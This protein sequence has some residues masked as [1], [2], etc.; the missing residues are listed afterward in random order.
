M[1]TDPL[2]RELSTRGTTPQQSGDSGISSAKF[3]ATYFDEL[4]LYSGQYALFYVIMNLSENRWNY[5]TNFGHTV[6]LAVLLAQTLFLA[7]MGKK[8]FT[9]LL[10]SLIAPL[11]YTLVELEEGIQFVLNGAHVFFWIY[12]FLTGLL[13]AFALRAVKRATS[14]VLE[15]SITTINVLAY[16]FIYYYFELR[17][18]MAKELAT[19]ALQ[20]DQYQEA[21]EIY[22]IFSGFSAFIRDP[23]HLYILIAGFILSLSMSTSRVKI[24]LLKDRIQELFGSY[25]DKNVSDRIIK[26][27]GGVPE[28]KNICVL[29]SDIRDF[30][31]LSERSTASE[32]TK[33]LNIYFTEWES[34]VD[35]HN[36][37]IDKFIGDA[38]MVVF[39]IDNNEHACK[40]A[41]MCA[42]E[43]L[44]RINV[45]TN[46][47]AAER[48][49]SFH[50]IGIGLHFGSVIVGDVGSTTRR[51]YTVIGDTVNI[52]S[53]LEGLCKHYATPLILS[54]AVYEHLPAG[55]QNGFVFLDNAVLKGKAARYH[56]YKS[57]TPFW[58][59]IQ[60]IEKRQLTECKTTSDTQE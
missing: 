37:T 24:L 28:R 16:L 38:I 20:Q 32:I 15:F 42:Q 9:R 17:L 19:G 57:V 59:R 47:L 2:E 49:P 58:Q 7:R 22:R 55:I 41:A 13:Q 29:F 56:I 33:M 46:R 21:L 10:G 34:V 3:A 52:A 39:G 44:A 4:L 27:D 6:L 35:R 31:S 36:G 48:L 43:M 45:V 14:A 60:N 5:F 51:N 30:T 12:S 53:R 23:S 11:C 1:T 25:V 40:D 26:H 18:D 50:D 54:N 8:P